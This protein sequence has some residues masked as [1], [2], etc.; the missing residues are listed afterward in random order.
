MSRAIPAGWLKAGRREY[1]HEDLDLEIE[2]LP[3][4]DQSGKF[5][6]RFEYD[7]EWTTIQNFQPTEKEGLELAKAAAA[8]FTEAYESGASVTDAIEQAVSDAGH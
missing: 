1:E 2:V 5:R 3:T 6:V 8:A 7:D 4:R